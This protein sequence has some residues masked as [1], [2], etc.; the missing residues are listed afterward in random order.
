M[1]RRKAELNSHLSI[2][3]RMLLKANSLLI[4]VLIAIFHLLHITQ[5]IAILFQTFKSLPKRAD[6]LLRKENYIYTVCLLPFSLS[7]VLR[8]CVHIP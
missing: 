4:T 2:P 1:F 7:G 6:C 3:D 5:H 8:G